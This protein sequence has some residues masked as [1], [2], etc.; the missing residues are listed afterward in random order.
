M[1]DDNRIKVLVVDDEEAFLRT[2]KAT[3]QKRG[4][5][6]TVASG[7]PDAFWKMAKRD[8]DV[9]VLDVKMPEMD[10]NEVLRKLKLMR[11]NIEVIMLTGHATV[12]SAL[13]GWRDEVFS[14]LRKPC[15]IEV[16]AETIRLAR[17]RR[18]QI[19]AAMEETS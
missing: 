16:L 17:A 5:D 10:G 12:D 7:G 15:D 8:I 4:F 6:V 14:Y 1:E 18:A 13:E 9:V 2:A 11:P 19:Q 3:L